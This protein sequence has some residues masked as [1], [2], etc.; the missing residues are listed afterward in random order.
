M[1]LNIQL[2]ESLQVTVIR[3]N[4][5][6]VPKGLDLDKVSSKYFKSLFIVQV[7]LV[8]KLRGKSA[9][10]GRNDVAKVDIT[11]KPTP[12]GHVYSA[13]IHGGSNQV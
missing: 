1:K 13:P 4:I 5:I 10:G 8:K 2:I 6:T 7:I 11:G 3:K 9:Q 12:A